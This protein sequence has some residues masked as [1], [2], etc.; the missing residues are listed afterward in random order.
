MACIK[1][2]QLE[3]EAAPLLQPQLQ[4][5]SDD[6]LDSVPF[7]IFTHPQIPA[8]G[9]VLPTFEGMCLPT[10]ASLVVIISPGHA[11]RL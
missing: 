7:P 3:L 8:P 6:L 4:A 11:Q 2:C 1:V 9:T 5:E 10:S